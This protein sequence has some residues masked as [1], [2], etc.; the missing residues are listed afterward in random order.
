MATDVEIQTGLLRD[1]AIG[2]VPQIRTR[3]ELLQALTEAA[4]LEHGLMLQYMFAAFTI[5]TGVPDDGAGSPQAIAAAERARAA[6]RAI[7]GV[8]REEMVHLGLVCNLLAAV[9]G[10]AWFRRPRFPAPQRYFPHR[11]DDGAMRYVVF[12]L[13]RLTP[14][15]VTRFIRFEQPEPLL[16]E[17]ALVEYAT[18]GQLYGEIE[19]H[20]LRADEAALFVG[21][22]RRQETDEWGNRFRLDA[23]VDAASA[24][25]AIRRIVEEGEGTPTGGE[26]SHHQRFLDV[27]DGL[28]LTTPAKPVGSNPVASSVEAT[29]QRT[30]VTEP[31][32][33]GLL[34]LF[35]RLYL[36]MLLLLEQI[37]RF[38]PELRAERSELRNAIRR[39]MSAIIRPIG[40]VLTD[41]PS[42]V[43]GRNAGPSFEIEEGVHLSDHAPGALVVIQERLRED[44]ARAHEIS[45]P[46]EP[47]SR[48][49][50]I[51]QSVSLLER[52]IG[53]MRAR[54]PR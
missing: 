20:V 40:E 32:A 2:P 10:D 3:T 35:N 46:G 9:G 12:S 5:P 1:A 8:A 4:E 19:R 7:L 52:S 38:P 23:I 36:T 42:G 49:P 24:V 43:P 27:R 13:D 6:K 45:R 28:P 11:G 15:S 53:H 37:Y 17:A 54:L 16:S 50:E 18:V 47:L 39:T 41:L 25:T 51:A 44:S 48:R 14:Q 26:L 30:P 22:R 21:P 31:G 33:R 29:E 34:E